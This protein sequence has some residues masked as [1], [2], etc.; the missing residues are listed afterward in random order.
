M[1]GA[2]IIDYVKWRGDLSL[3]QSEFNDAD[4]LILSQISYIPFEGIVPSVRS[5]RHITMRDAAQKLYKE[6][7][8]QNLS[9]GALIPAEI[10][11]L[12]KIAGES[13]RFGNLKLC[14]YVNKINEATEVQFCA[15]TVLDEESGMVYLA[16]RGTDD[17]IIG[18]KENFNMSYMT[19]VPAQTEAVK[20]FNYVTAQVIKNYG[21]NEFI[22]GGHSKGGNLSVYAAAYGIKKVLNTQVKVLKVYNFDGPGFDSKVTESREYRDIRENIY[23]YVPQSSVVGML[24]GHEDVYTVVKS[25]KSGLMQH[26]ALTWEVLGKEFVCVERVT[27]SSEFFDKSMR[28]WISKLS[29]ET[30][31]AFVNAVFDI[32]TSTDANTLTDLIAGGNKSFAAIFKAY[33]D[34]NE[35]TK[36]MIRRTIKSMMDIIKENL[37][38]INH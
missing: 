23:T 36:Q 1:E 38:K 20:Y 25:T 18:W 32:L 13:R 8:V 5:V 11:E 35:E 26:N 3:S 33:T 27:Q 12:F 10:Y 37:K 19:P 31:Q 4:S 9:L 15:L 28:E 30:A 29:P 21:M 16:Y 7:D 2:N 6:K 22:L 24:L 34:E 14:R 17:T